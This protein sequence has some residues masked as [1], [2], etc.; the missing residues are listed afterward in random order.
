MQGEKDL[1]T[2]VMFEM[3]RG[4]S[5]GCRALRTNMR[6]RMSAERGASPGGGEADDKSQTAAVIVPQGG[7]VYRTFCWI[8][9]DINGL[10]RNTG[11]S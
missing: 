11:T 5:E 6:T 2:C 3:A 7:D 1:H 4:H 8:D 9:W 10:L